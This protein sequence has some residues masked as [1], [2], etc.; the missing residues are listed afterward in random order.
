[1]FGYALLL[2][3]SSTA[4]NRR[5]VAVDECLYQEGS[6]GQ[7]FK[8]DENSVVE[9]LESLEEAT[10]G[11]IRLEETAGLRQVY[12]DESLGENYEDQALEL[13]KGHYEQE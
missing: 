2:F 10:K 4:E 8:L 12:L 5:T 7:I 13:L 3:L 1:M 6:P 11:K 9:Y